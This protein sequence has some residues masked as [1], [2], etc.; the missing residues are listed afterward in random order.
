MGQAI[1]RC[2]GI[3]TGIYKLW[4]T[5]GQ[6]LALVKQPDTN[7]LRPDLRR[8]ID[9]PIKRVVVELERQGPHRQAD[10]DIAMQAL[11]IRQ[12]RPQPG[13]GQRAEERRGGEEWVRTWRSRW[14]PYTK[15]KN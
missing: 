10:G 13:R 15:K 9:G 14:S 3:G 8:M 1:Q 12:A 2:G 4:N 7:R 5:D 11:D 6:Q